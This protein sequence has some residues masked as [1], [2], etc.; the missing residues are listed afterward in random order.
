MEA[1][2]PSI[3]L[4]NKSGF[5]FVLGTFRG[6]LTISI[7]KREEGK[8]GFGKQL[9]NFSLS[10]Q[11]IQHVVGLLKSAHGLTPETQKSLKITGYVDGKRETVGAM[12]VGK[13]DKQIFY[14]EMQNVKLKD[15]RT[16]TER[17][18][19]WIPSNFQ[20]SN[21]EATQEQV[22]A[23]A[24]NTLVWWLTTVA[25]LGMVTCNYRMEKPMDG[26]A[27]SSSSGDMPF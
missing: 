14:I 24:V 23:D 21:Y 10:I 22:S 6:N 15:G 9:Q 19:L 2:N 20:P 16:L 25:P 17:W 26:R 1:M 5:L 18:N 4:A 7:N 3:T 11:D 27:P 12:C 8:R 13:D